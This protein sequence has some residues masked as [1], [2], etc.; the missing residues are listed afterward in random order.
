MI[1]SYSEHGPLFTFAYGK[2][3]STATSYLSANNTN[4]MAK[5]AGQKRQAAQA[6]LDDEGHKGTRSKTTKEAEANRRTLRSSDQ[7]NSIVGSSPKNTTNGTSPNNKGSARDTPSLQNT[8]NKKAKIIKKGIARPVVKSKKN[9]SSKV[10]K[11]GSKSPTKAKSTVRAGNG[12]GSSLSEVSIP[13]HKKAGNLAADTAADE[14]D[15]DGPS[16]WLMKAEPESRIE[17]GK[18]VK[19]S[20]DDL[21]NATEPEAWDGEFF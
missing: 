5:T 11:N 3:T 15:P 17:K 6:D 10:S 19:F 1:D 13:T 20:I 16:Y 18:D 12:R 14:D 9:A 2:I 4:T 21:K 7:S 8:P